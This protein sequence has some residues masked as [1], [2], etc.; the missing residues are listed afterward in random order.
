VR[1]PRSDTG[2][3][4]VRSRSARRLSASVSGSPGRGRRPAAGSGLTGRRTRRG[5]GEGNLERDTHLSVWVGLGP[6]AVVVAA[7]NDDFEPHGGQCASLAAGRRHVRPCQSPN[8]PAPARLRRGRTLPTTAG[9]E[10][11]ARTVAHWSAGVPVPAAAPRRPA[12]TPCVGGAGPRPGHP[13]RAGERRRGLGFPL[14]TVAPGRAGRR[15]AQGCRHAEA[16]ADQ[17]RKLN[18]LRTRATLRRSAPRRARTRSTSSSSAASPATRPSPDRIGAASGAPRP[19]FSGDPDLRR[20]VLQRAGGAVTRAGPDPSRLRP[21]RCRGSRGRRSC[22][23]WRAA[24]RPGSTP[25]RS[26]GRWGG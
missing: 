14:A 3:Q 18:N 23:R 26:R 11:L 12:R 7:E 21:P 22:W 4:S 15:A 9:T 16:E 19:L 20:A 8:D 17:L 5:A 1:S 25:R 10:G 24:C 2:G 6:G 13:P